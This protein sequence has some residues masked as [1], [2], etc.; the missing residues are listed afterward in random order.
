M[1]RVTTHKYYCDRCGKEI[2]FEHVTPTFAHYLI[3]GNSWVTLYES[4][5]R[6]YELCHECGKKLAKFIKNEELT[7]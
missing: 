5:D 6:Y 3:L 4:K 2:P 7:D 1:S